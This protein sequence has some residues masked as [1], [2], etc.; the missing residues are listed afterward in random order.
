M[1]KISYALGINVGTNLLMAG[2]NDIN[3][4]D[5]ADA[6]RTIMNGEKVKMSGSEINKTLND[7]FAELED[8]KKKQLEQEAKVN[9]AEGKEFLKKNGELEDVVT[10]P[11]GLQYKV[12]NKGVGKK[13]HSHSQVEV[14]YEGR[15]INGEKFDSSYDRGETITFGLDGVIKGWAEGLQQMTEGSKYE[16]Y[17][18]YDLAY[19]ENGVPGIPPCATL[20]FTVELIKV[21]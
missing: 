3:V 15:F 21:K 18:P 14:H 12:I 11:S 20:I 7:F 1:D 2:V 5:F 4:N 9:K 13:P 16:L 8:D 6:I 17:I 19:G 10:L